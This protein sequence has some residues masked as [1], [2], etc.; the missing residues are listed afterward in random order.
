MREYLTLSRSGDL[1]LHGKHQLG[2][3][4]QVLAAALLM[5]KGYGDAPRQVV[6]AADH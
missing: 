6:H 4:G 1:V 3:S 5:L 2:F